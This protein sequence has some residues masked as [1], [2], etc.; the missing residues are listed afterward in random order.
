M[1]RYSYIAKWYPGGTSVDIFGIDGHCVGGFGVPPI[2]CAACLGP[3]FFAF[4]CQGGSTY[5]IDAET[6]GLMVV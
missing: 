6:G 5:I 1:G 4:N 3:R 2:V